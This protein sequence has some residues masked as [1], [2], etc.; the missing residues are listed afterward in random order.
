MQYNI[1]NK[2]KLAAAG[3]IAL[4]GGVAMAGQVGTMTTFTAGSPAVAADVNA[5]FSEHT[6]QINDNA[7]R[8]TAIENQGDPNADGTFDIA[9]IAGTY[10]GALFKMGNFVKGGA[11]ARDDATGLITGP[12]NYFLDKFGTGALTVTIDNQG[13]ATIH[14]VRERAF[15]SQHYTGIDAA[16]NTSPAFDTSRSKVD[17]SCDVTAVT[18]SSANVVNGGP[19]EQCDADGNAVDN[20]TGTQDPPAMTFVVIS[21]AMRSIG[22]DLID[23]TTGDKFKLRGYVSK[24]G[25]IITLRIFERWCGTGFNASTGKCTG[26]TFVGYGLLT[27]TR[28]N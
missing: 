2:W 16:D 4:Y 19:L 18:A 26:G 28:V 10:G 15:E 9:D 6:T 27:L 14:I 11:Y 12:D 23:N 13:V 21:P 8:I 5:N 7:T 20:S 17:N 1:S 24:D 25:N 3:L 22:S